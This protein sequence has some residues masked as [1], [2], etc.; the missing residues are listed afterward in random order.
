MPSM[1]RILSP[2]KR[3]LGA[4]LAARGV[5][6]QT[7]WSKNRPGER[8]GAGHSSDEEEV[9]GSE[10]RIGG[11]YDNIPGPRGSPERVIH[12]VPIEVANS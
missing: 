5:R 12:A 1:L 9:G 2:S 3:N 6:R 4:E 11:G 10:E 7:N 8:S